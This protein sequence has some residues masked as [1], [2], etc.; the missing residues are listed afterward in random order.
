[1]HFAPVVNWYSGTPLATE[2][3]LGGVPV[4]PNGRGDLGRTPMFFQGD[5][6][7]THDIKLKSSETRYFRLELNVT[8]LFNNAAVA[9]KSVGITHPNDGDIQFVNITD[10]FKGYRNYRALMRAQDIRVN[11]QFGLASAFQGPR[12][13]RMGFHFFF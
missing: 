2:I 13:L 10:I 11:P 3:Q 12:T 4:Y 6:L 5:L 8:N 9:N 1:M 7:L